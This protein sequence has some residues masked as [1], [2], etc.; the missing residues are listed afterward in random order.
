M[1]KEVEA[2]FDVFANNTSTIKVKKG[3][4]ILSKE[5]YAAELYKMMEDYGDT[6][7]YSTNNLKEGDFVEGE[8]VMI[9]TE[10]IALDIRYKDYLYVDC[11]SDE[12]NALKAIDKTVGDKVNVMI[13]HFNSSSFEIRG[14]FTKYLRQSAENKMREA[15]NDDATVFTCFIKEITPAGYLVDVISDGLK[16]PAFM[17][18]TLAGVNKLHDPQALVGTTLEIMLD[19]FSTERKTFIASR[20]K[21][22]Q[23]LVPA[24]IDSMDI[25]DDEGEHISYEGV[26]TGVAPYGVFIEVNG[27]TSGLLH[28]S[29]IEPE[30]LADMSKVKPGVVIGFYIKEKLKDRLILTRVVRETIWDTIRAGK[31]YDGK[32]KDNKSFG[33]LI[34]LDEETQGLIHT[35]ELEKAGVKLTNGETIRV[36][37]LAV[38]RDERKIFLTLAPKRKGKNDE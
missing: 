15:S 17:P 35:A 11:K 32:V 26:I 23:T 10:H 1:S 4:K 8:I 31:I 18:N 33:A 37:V 16:F 2:A 13:T 29:N 6:Y 9:T 25:T 5:P 34:Q 14:S 3:E 19:G 28:N 21:Y 20:K 7:D 27:C 38:V 36:K 12:L 30:L 24:T 22:L